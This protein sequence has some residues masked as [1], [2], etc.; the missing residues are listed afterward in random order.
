MCIRTALPPVAGLALL[1]IACGDSLPP[2]TDA[3]AAAQADV[4]RAQAGGAPSVPE[5]KLHLQLAEEDLKKSKELMNQDNRRSTSLV[6]VARAEA[7]LALSMAN[8]EAAQGVLR[9]AQEDLQKSK[10]A[11]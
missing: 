3:W 11:Q 4:G 8:A 1:L 9:K 10:G 2:P 5:A 7:R 6:E